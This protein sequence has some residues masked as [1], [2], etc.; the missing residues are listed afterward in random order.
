[1]TVYINLFKEIEQLEKQNK[2]LKH[3]LIEERETNRRL[4]IELSKLR[5][6]IHIINI[7]L[8]PTEDM[9][10][11]NINQVLD[12]FDVIRRRAIDEYYNQQKS[13]DED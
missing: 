8:E 13:E 1:M 6:L 3:Q 9:A 10:C 11:R 7:A 12:K 5:S 2:V 4:A